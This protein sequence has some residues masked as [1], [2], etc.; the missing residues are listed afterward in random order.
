M[1]SGTRG[2]ES[3]AMRIP[4]F[5]QQGSGDPSPQ[6]EAVPDSET[7]RLD[8]LQSGELEGVFATPDWLRDL[9]YSSWM[10]LG[11]AALLFAFI[12]LLA[13][14]STIVLPVTAGFIVASVS[15]PIVRKLGDRG[16]PRAA[17]AAIVLLGIVLIAAAVFWMVL[18]GIMS[19]SDQISQAANQAADK[20]QGWLTD[21]G[22]SQSSASNATSSTQTAVPQAVSTLVHGAT[23]LIG[24]L[25]SLAF[26][27]SFTAFAIF[28]LLKDGPKMRAWTNQHM[29]VPLP[30]AEIITGNVVLSLRRYFAGVTVV[31]AFNAVVVGIGALVLDVPLAGTIAVVTF[32][33]AYVPFIGAFVSGAFAVM[34]ALGTQGTDTAIAMLVIVILANGGLQNIVQPIAFGATLRLNPLLVLVVTIGAGALFGMIGLVL[35][36]PLT[37]AL[38]Q[39][40]SQLGAVRRAEPGGRPEPPPHASPAMQS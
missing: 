17:G 36:A 20:V 24:G 11:V 28:F 9:G 3:Q 27:L 7:P 18:R 40:S 13:A 38:F 5:W 31:A 35:A 26:A 2:E 29:G 15:A 23:T 10:L 14:T 37:S 39:I 32:V 33:T 4:R 19:E 34:L 22:A 8:A 25:T 12:L 1:K 6:R 21:A 30:V 16:V